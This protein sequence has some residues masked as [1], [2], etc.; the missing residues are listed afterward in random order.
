[1]RVYGASQPFYGDFPFARQLIHGV[2]PLHVI[3]APTQGTGKSLL[4]EVSILPFAADGVA[5]TPALEGDEEWRKK[6]TSLLL[7][8]KT[9]IWV[10][11]INH[12]LDSASLAS[13]LTSMM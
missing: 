2:T 5:A 6:I 3:D 9:H 13:A 11:N 4:A 12:K 1:M 8:A 10:H 7:R